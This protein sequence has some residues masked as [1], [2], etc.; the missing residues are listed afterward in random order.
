[1]KCM[2]LI[3]FIIMP[4]QF[5]HHLF[6][7]CSIFSFS[8]CFDGYLFASGPALHFLSLFHSLLMSF[9]CVFLTVNV[10]LCAD[11]TICHITLCGIVQAFKCLSYIYVLWP[12][13]SLAFGF[14]ALSF[15]VLFICLGLLRF[16]IT[17]TSANIWLQL[18]SKIWRHIQDDTS[19]RQINSPLQAMFP[20][21]FVWSKVVFNNNIII[22][23]Y[24]ENQK[25]MLHPVLFQF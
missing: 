20:L 2:V 14:L 9:T 10:I 21:L 1:M 3:S 12:C 24:S 18:S 16:L 25:K 11:V 5:I 17:L 15:K 4:A 7:W 19:A 23:Q 13:E 8:T 6:G 22:K